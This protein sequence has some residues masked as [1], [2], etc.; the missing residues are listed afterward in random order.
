MLQKKRNASTFTPAGDKKAIPRT[1]HMRHVIILFNYALLLALLA[2]PYQVNA[3]PLIATN[4]QDTSNIPQSCIIFG[5]ERDL[6]FL[7]APIKSKH[8]LDQHVALLKSKSFHSPLR[9]LS[10]SSLERFVASISFNEKGI[11]GYLYDDLEKELTLSQAYE[12]LALFG[13]QYNLWHLA[14]AKV[15]TELD[16]DIRQ[17][18]AKKREQE[19][20]AAAKCSG[21][22]DRSSYWCS[23]RATCSNRVGSICL[24]T[25]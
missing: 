10:N 12:I 6:Q 15:S 25:C 20:S 14:N 13:Q 7:A 3:T 1:L 23:S 8:D 5:V 4:P 11:T 19:N 2:I 16:S 21:P 18:I 24:S 17:F 9:Y 22:K